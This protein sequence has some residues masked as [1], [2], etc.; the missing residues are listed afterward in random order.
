MLDAIGKSTRTTSVEAPR[1][2]VWG[3]DS[4]NGAPEFTFAE[5]KIP[6]TPHSLAT[7]G[8]AMLQ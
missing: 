2:Y 7:G 1:G 3:Y 8:R 5:E 6:R 4:D